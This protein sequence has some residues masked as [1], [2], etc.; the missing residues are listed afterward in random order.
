MTGEFDKETGNQEARH[1][2][3]VCA[4]GEGGLW[5][6]T[7]SPSGSSDHLPVLGPKARRRMAEAKAYESEDN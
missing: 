6:W 2:R 4:G 5:S 1:T 7:S 3:H